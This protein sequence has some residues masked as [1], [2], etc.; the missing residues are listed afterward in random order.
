VW[1]QAAKKL[2]QERVADNEPF[3][4]LYIS[5]QNESQDAFKPSDAHCDHQA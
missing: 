1:W 5:L 2:Q 3:I 4:T